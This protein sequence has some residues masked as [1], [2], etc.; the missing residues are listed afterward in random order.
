MK[1]WHKTAAVGL[2]ALALAVAAIV[3]AYR[4]RGNGPEDIFNRVSDRIG[5][6]CGCNQPLSGCNH[7]PCGSADPMRVQI[8]AAIAAGQNEQA[9][10]DEFVQQYGVKVLSAPPARGFQLTAW[11]MPFLAL[12]LGLVVVYRVV[13][14]LRARALAADADDPARAALLERYAKAIDEELERE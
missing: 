10:V 8:R 1:P 13:S 7:H 3:G 5:C 14:H 6:Q 9:I 4:L 11:V 12:L 2:A